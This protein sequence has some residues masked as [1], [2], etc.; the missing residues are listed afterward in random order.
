MQLI[1]INLL[2]T[3]SLSSGRKT[4]YLG[5]LDTGKF[6]EG[7]KGEEGRGRQRKEKGDGGGRGKESMRKREKENK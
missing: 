3:L 5:I 4:S 7:G 1:S 2:V 6:W